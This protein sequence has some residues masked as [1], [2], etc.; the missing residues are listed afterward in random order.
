MKNETKKTTASLSEQGINA[1][2]WTYL[3]KFAAMALQFFIG[4]I[5]ARILGPEPYGLVAIALL[6]VGLGGLLAE[7]GLGAALIQSPEITSQDI[8]SVFSTQLVIGWCIAGL[9]AS[10]APW[11]ADFFNNPAAVPVIMVMTLTFL[12]QPFGQTATALFRRRL[13]FKT[14]QIVSLASYLVGYL[15]IG[16]PLAYSGFGVWSLVTAQ[17][18]QISIKAGLAYSLSRHPI[19]P[20]V[21]PLHCRFLNI[22]SAI[23]ANNV[24]SWLMVSLDTAIIGRCFGTLALGLYN[25]TFTLVN[26]PMMA[27]VTG[28]QGVLLSAYSKSQENG[29]ALIRTYSVSVGMMALLF[30]PIFSAAAAVPETIILGLYGEKWLP[31]I[32]LFVPL[33]YAMAEYAM[34]AMA[35]PLLTAIGKPKLE[36]KAQLIGLCGMVPALIIAGQYSIELFAWVLLAMYIQRFMLL[37]VMS[38]MAL[39]HP[40]RKL[41]SFLPAPV[42]LS[43]ILFFLAHSVDVIMMRLTHQAGVRLICI[44]IICA[45]VYPILLVWLRNLIVRGPTR[46]FRLSISHVLPQPVLRLA[47][48]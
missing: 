8:R 30:L 12:I 47:G 31:A 13:E 26:M 40:P 3:G 1:L 44:I 37:T 17:L 23:T 7:G 43:I 22:G 48:L 10:F 14:L 42:L 25:R 27:I 45:V 9:L 24:T 35:G 34:L 33:A 2:K 16:I 18:L 41:F 32:S 28:A 4:I 6:I 5:L 20:L 36:L 38:L 21:N 11:I 19:L 46:E 39:G 15:L 29:L